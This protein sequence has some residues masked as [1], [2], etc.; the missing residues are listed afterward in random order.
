ML[1]MVAHGHTPRTPGLGGLDFCADVGECSLEFGFGKKLIGD[2]FADN[3][4]GDEIA[5][6]VGTDEDSVPSDLLAAGDELVFEGGKELAE[7]AG[8]HCAAGGVAAGIAAFVFLL[9]GEDAFVAEDGTFTGEEFFSGAG[10]AFFAFDFD[11]VKE[12]FEFGEFRGIERRSEEIGETVDVHLSDLGL[13]GGEFLGC[14]GFLGGDDEVEFG[15][16]FR[17]IRRDGRGENP[18]PIDAAE[19][20]IMKGRRS[21]CASDGGEKEEKQ[22]WFESAHS[23]PP[24]R[25]EKAE[26]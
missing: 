18:F 8:V 1:R 10:D 21:V 17:G 23:G 3:A 14:G 22:A 13:G 4:A 16:L 19:R 20:Q 6:V 11:G 12:G 25:M 9:V 7:D 26:V 15:V 5:W 24:R 2:G